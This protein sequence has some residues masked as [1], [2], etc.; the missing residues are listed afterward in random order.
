MKQSKNS[1]KIVL[2]TEVNV[3][4]LKYK[5]REQIIII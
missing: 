4:G 1:F 2:N 5:I 3:L